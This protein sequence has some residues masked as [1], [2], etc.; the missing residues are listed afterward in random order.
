MSINKDELDRFFVTRSACGPALK[1]FRGLPD[2]ITPR[3]AWNL[4]ERGDWLLWAACVV[5]VDKRHIV[6]AAIG[7]FLTTEGA[8][9]PSEAEQIRDIVAKC[10][11]Y[12][13]GVAPFR[14]DVFNIEVIRC[15]DQL[16]MQGEYHLGYA[17]GRLRNVVDAD[18]VGRQALATGVLLTEVYQVNTG[19]MRWHSCGSSEVTE[20][21]EACDAGDAAMRE[22][23]NL[24]RELLSWEVVEAALD[25]QAVAAEGRAE[26]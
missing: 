20:I 26:T 7:V 13:E 21:C 15:T 12:G 23:T 18:N 14:V 6:S 25:K 17:L 1:W 9:P 3:E 2:T 24:V 16:L 11:A 8:W 5:G 10:R 4:C 22:L 19:H